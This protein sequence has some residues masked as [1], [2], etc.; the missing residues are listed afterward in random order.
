MKVSQIATLLNTVTQEVL[1]ESVVVTED[2]SNVVDLG[3]A[4]YNTDQV[5]NYMRKLMDQIG[6][7]VF[8]DRPY[9][10][11]VPSVLMDS[12]EYGSVLEKIRM[13]LPEA[14]ENQSWELQNGQSYDDH[15]F[16][17]P[18][19][20]AKFYNSKTTFEVRMS[21]ADRQMKSAFTSAAQM[22]SFISMIYTQIENSMTV[23]IDALVMRVINNMIAE[24]LAD[25]F[26]DG[27]YTGVTSVRAVN[28][29]YMYNEATGKSLTRDQA[30]MESD[31]Y[32]FAAKTWAE[33]VDELGV[34]SR[35]YNAGATEKFTP[36]DRLHTVMLSRF[37]RGAEMY[38]YSDTYHDEY[39]KLPRAEI[40]PY[41][42]GSG[43]D[44]SIDQASTIDVKTASGKSVKASGIIGVMFDRDALGVSNYNRRI[45]SQYTASAEFTTNWYKEDAGYFNDTDEN[46][47]VFY[48]A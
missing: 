48:M 37:A 10:G 9:R 5:E 35:L 25:E 34:L 8:V 41:W 15:I 4:V 36:R 42:Q 19:V 39:V 16:Y 13:E 3:A 32:K 14:V 33:Y 28:V 40:V 47:I 43:T 31:F 22:G 12:W 1:G 21:I 11:R 44:R 18:T 38:L 2:L 20:T 27:V 6:K 45:T 46:F 7:V 29:L 26:E 23:K 30:L 17:S 24:T